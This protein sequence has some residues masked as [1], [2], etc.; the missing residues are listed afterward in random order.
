MQICPVEFYRD[1]SLLELAPNVETAAIHR[2]RRWHHAKLSQENALAS[3]FLQMTYDYS[4]ANAP[5]GMLEA[6]G[7]QRSVFARLALRLD[8]VWGRETGGASPHFLP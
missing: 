1:L 2:F 3:L 8:V 4:A 7:S 5:A 6:C